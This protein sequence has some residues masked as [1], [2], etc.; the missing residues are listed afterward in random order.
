MGCSTPIP[1]TSEAVFRLIAG[2]HEKSDMKRSSGC[3]TA[4][5]DKTAASYNMPS[6][7]ATWQTSIHHNYLKNQ[8]TIFSCQPLPLIDK[9]HTYGLIV[10]I[11]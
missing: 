11:L 2:R 8:C 10:S 1:Y 3:F 7:G 6:Q 5:R 9:Y 4:E